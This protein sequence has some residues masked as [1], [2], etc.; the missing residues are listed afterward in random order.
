MNTITTRRTAIATLV[1]ASLFAGGSANAANWLK[2]QGT[3]E[4]HKAERAHLWGFIQ[5]EYEYTDDT[6]LAAGPWQGQDAAFNQIP[7][8]LDSSSTFQ[9][10]RARIGVRGTPIPKNKKVNYFFLAEFGNN[11]ITNS[12]GDDG[13]AR[14]SDASITL[15]YIPGARVRVGQFKYPGSEEGWQA[16]M[17]HNY[18]N[19]T[20]VTN[21]LNLERFFDEDGSDPLDANPRNGPVN[22]FRDIGVQVFDWFEMGDWEHSYAA[23]LGNGN[24]ITRSDNNDDKDL[25]L[26]WSSAKVFGG[27]RGRRQDWKL[28]AWANTGD[29]TIEVAQGTAGEGDD[30]EKTFDRDRW[31]IGTTYRKGKWRGKAEYIKADGMIF[32]GTDGGAVPG[33]FSND[34]S[35]IASFNVLPEEE[36]DG[37]YVDVGYRVL[38]DLELDVRYDIL[39]RATESDTNERQFETWTLGFQY[40]FN[41][42]TRFTFNYEFR[43]AEAPELPGSAPPNQILD[44]F[45]DRVS[46]NVFMFF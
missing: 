12:D 20:Q 40:F 8:D 46:A 17:V 44:G 42:K 15:N 33:S 45:D 6:N 24:G 5:P 23:M 14:I 34:G 18:I 29:R 38:P 11:G 22:A 37:W 36:A 31:G 41:K 39:N 25:Y 16:I 21:Q 13:P 19:F 27:K 7:P 1:A 3:Q 30:V 10:R 9:I 43:D 26:Y 2:L 28:F 32:A 35:R 4:A